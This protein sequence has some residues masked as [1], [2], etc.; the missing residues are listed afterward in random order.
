MN[1]TFAAICPHPS[2]ALP[3]VGSDLVKRVEKTIKAMK[4]LAEGLDA[5]KPD[6]IIVISSHMPVSLA[7]FSIIESSELKGHFYKFGDF[8]SEMKFDNHP[9]MVS[10]IKKICAEERIPLRSFDDPEMD[11]GTTISLHFLLQ[12]KPGMKV[13]PVGVAGL[14]P[15]E[16]LNFGKVIAK[17][18]K[19]CDLKIA[20]VAS[21]ELSHRLS[22]SSSA[23][24]FPKSKEFDLMMMELLKRGDKSAILEIDSELLDSSAE[25]GYLPIT[26]LLGALDDSW[27]GEILSYES[28]FGIGYLVA[29]LKKR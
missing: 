11:Y 14:S 19:D 10:A 13:V 24:Y 17:A 20:I 22:S 28:P 15:M 5:A 7:S 2:V 18:A 25:C 8:K 26:I 29:N 16:H 3:S 27:K 9:A 21:G 23:G 1:I 4:S 6:A 12:D